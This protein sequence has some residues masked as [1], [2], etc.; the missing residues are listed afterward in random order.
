MTL[1]FSCTASELKDWLF[2]ENTSSGWID[3]NDFAGGRVR[4]W[5]EMRPREFILPKD[6]VHYDFWGSYISSMTFAASPTALRTIIAPR[7]AAACSSGKTYP[8]MWRTLETLVA[9]ID[10]LDSIVPSDD[11]S[12]REYGTSPLTLYIG[13]DAE[14][15]RLDQIG[16]LRTVGEI[17][18]R[19]VVC[20]TEAMHPRT[21][22]GLRRAIQSECRQ[23]R[24]DFV[25]CPVDVCVYFYDTHVVVQAYS[26]RAAA[27]PE[28]FE[29][30][31]AVV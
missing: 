26:A 9:N 25:T 1:C 7:V 30:C 24:V 27:R 6:S 18:E 28:I 31:E 21:R 5:N 11:V 4:A 3:P 15:D 22:S 17:T 20:S 19:V 12:T 2:D 23:A 8:V 16:C 13:I 14:C 10:V 29:Q